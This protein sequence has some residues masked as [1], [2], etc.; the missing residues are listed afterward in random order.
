MKVLLVD[1]LADRMQWAERYG[2]EIT[3]RGTV[4][5]WD[6]LRHIQLYRCIP[7]VYVDEGYRTDEVRRECAKYLSWRNVRRRHGVRTV[8][9][10][11]EEAFGHA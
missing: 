8:A 5:T 11:I 3:E 2:D 4:T 9:N 1:V 7:T 10:E 6:E